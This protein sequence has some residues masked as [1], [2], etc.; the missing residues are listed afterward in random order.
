MKLNV[1]L[2]YVYSHF[3]IFIQTGNNSSQLLPPGGSR[4]QV[5]FSIVIEGQFTL[6]ALA[7]NHLTTIKNEQ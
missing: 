4:V 3:I 2:W 6:K 5:V 7:L 1:M